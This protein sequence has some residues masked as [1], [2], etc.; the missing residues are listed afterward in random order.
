[1]PRLLD[2]VLA[3]VTDPR[4]G[5]AIAGDLLEERSFRAVRSRSRA[6]IWFWFASAGI[7]LFAAT[8]KGRAAMRQSIVARFGFREPGREVR[9]SVRSLWRARWY[10]VTVIG[11]IALSM[12]LATATFAMVDGVLF[13]PLPFPASDEVYIAGG[14]WLKQPYQRVAVSSRDARDWAAANPELGIAVMSFAGGAAGGRVGDFSSRPLAAAA[15]GPTFFEVVGVRPVLGGFQPDDFVSADP[16]GAA[17]ISDGVWQS[18]FGGRPDVIGQRLE[19]FGS[20]R[21]VR[22]VGVLPAGFVMP[23][24][25]AQPDL[26]YPL[27]LTPK[28]YESRTRRS[29]ALLV[30]VPSHIG[31]AAAQSRLD[32]AAQAVMSDWPADSRLA[33]GAFD[34]VNLTQAESLLTSRT[35][36]TF[37]VLFAASGVLVLLAALNLAG[38]AAARAEDRWREIGLRRALGAGAWSLMRLQFTEMIVLASIGAALGLVL[39]PLFSALTL[40]LLPSSTLLLK[41]PAIDWRVLAFAALATIVVAVVV[42]LWPAVVATRQR[43]AGAADQAGRTTTRGGRIGRRVLIAAQ[44]AV[45]LVLTIG[46]TLVV[47]SLV[48]LWSEHPG[49]RPGT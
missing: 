18:H 36:P 1:M 4:I 6:A 11:V 33:N 43:L 37:I 28:D 46:G 21:A 35:R 31:V 45:G 41:P 29:F 26:V 30:R 34:H 32:A 10:S 27:V 49:T 39:T 22:V 3:R 24:E 44:V 47:G 2:A 23:A 25:G 13:K 12:A 15:V 19:F 17:L 38:L 9:Q 8:E 16:V 42:S 48:L 20:T 5:S 7:I 14:S 40:R